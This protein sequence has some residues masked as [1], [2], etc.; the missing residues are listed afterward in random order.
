[1]KLLFKDHSRTFSLL[2]LL[3]LVS[4]SQQLS[5]EKHALH[6]QIN[7]L[8]NT[9]N[10]L[11]LF[12]KY[13]TYLGDGLFVLIFSVLILLFNIRLGLALLVSYIFASLI[14][15]TLKHL[16]FPSM[17]RPAYV[18]Q[19]E[20]LHPL[21]LVE[22]V[23]MHIHNSFPSGHSTAAFV[24]FMTISFFLK[25]EFAKKVCL[26]LAAVVAFSRVYLSQHFLMDITAGAIIGSIVAIIIS[27]FFFYRNGTGILENWNRP[28]FN[29]NRQ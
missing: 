17:N 25:S 5:T 26:L 18:F 23:D 12:F 16:V 29:R 9:N 24:F 28:L 10:L 22:G 20:D 11:D 7:G 21:K 19:W 4:I 8:V 14:S 6:L 1:M 13:I 15:T 2:A 3:L 27:Y